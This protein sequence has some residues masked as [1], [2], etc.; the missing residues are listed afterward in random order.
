L[1]VV[2]VG[3]VGLGT[4]GTHIARL[5]LDHRQGIEIVGAF[6]LESESVGRSL[7]DVVGAA[8]ASTVS[9]SDQLSDVLATGPD[10]VLHATQSFLED[11]ADQIFACIAAGANVISCA[12]EL[13]YPQ[14]RN[15]ALAMKLDDAAKEAG[16]TIVGSGVN[17]GFL[18]DSFLAK[19]TSICWDIQSISG[20]RVVDVS[21]FGEAIHRR[22]GIGYPANEFSAGHEN[23]TIAGHVGF[24]ESIA[25]VL[26]TLG[27]ALDEPV[28]ESF[29]P[30]IAT[31]SV[32]TRYGAV[33]AG[34][35]EGFIQRAVGRARGEDFI[36][37][38]LVL[39]L[40]PEARGFPLMDTITISGE[41][42]VNLSLTP[43]PSALL[44]TSANI[45]NSIPSVLMAPPGVQV[46]TDLRPPAAWLG[47]LGYLAGDRS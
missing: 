36:R 15:P 27:L 44:S 37:L 7:S 17:P 41:Q 10:I 38:E 39:H 31:E 14:R 42:P 25:I 23:G 9:V 11:V 1:S 6:T 16:V 18:F 22:L 20:R 21:G 5:L 34:T 32:E 24:P 43:G 4:I 28:E 12:E 3:L 45:V 33:D 19:A 8:T 30:L 35:T 46:V 29:E 2:K 13:A 40:Q 47:G 26:R